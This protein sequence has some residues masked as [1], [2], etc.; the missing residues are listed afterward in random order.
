MV[1][2]LCSFRQPPPSQLEDGCKLVQSIVA[3]LLGESSNRSDIDAT[4]RHGPSHLISELG[5]VRLPHEISRVIY[6]RAV[7][8]LDKFEYTLSQPT[9]LIEHFLES[10]FGSVNINRIGNQ[11]YRFQVLIY[12]LSACVCGCFS[13]QNNALE[14]EEWVP[15]LQRATRL[16]ACFAE[17]VKQWLPLSP[18]VAKWT[19]WHTLCAV[20]EM[21]NGTIL[22]EGNSKAHDFVFLVF[23]DEILRNVMLEDTPGSVF[24]YESSA[25]SWCACSSAWAFVACT[26]QSKYSQS[27]TEWLHKFSVLRNARTSPVQQ[28]RPSSP[29][30]ARTSMRKDKKS[31]AIKLF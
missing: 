19:R 10:V 5:G 15:A 31:I 27:G 4:L 25:F 30:R 11:S 24:D 12:N 3:V 13:A 1:S 18:D 20:L 29:R 14:R 8:G 23:C 28:Q 6:A 9:A 21:T 22:V 17:V 16:V 26:P 7:A 2:E